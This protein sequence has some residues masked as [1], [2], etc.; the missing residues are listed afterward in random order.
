MTTTA[1]T[2]SDYITRTQNLL[3]AG[4]GGNVYPNSVLIP[5]INQARAQVAIE[6]ECIRAVPPVNGPVSSFT[7]LTAGSGY[8][9][10]PPTVIVSAPDSPSG[11]GISAAG[12][13]ARA[14][15]TL[16]GGAVV[17]ITINSGTGGAGY[18]Q[19]IVTL[20]S[21]SGTGATAIVVVSGLN[22]TSVSQEVYQFS[23][24]TPMVATSGSGIQSVYEVNGITVIWG[25]FRYRMKTCSFSK[26]K[27]VG[28]PYT[29]GYTYIPAVYSQFGQ[30][31]NGSIYA[32][33]IAN[34]A[35]QWEWDCFCLPNDLNVAT[36]VEAL[37][38]PWT[39]AVPFYAAYYAY[40]QNGRM[41]DADRMWK[42]AGKMMTRARTFSRRR[43]VSNWYGR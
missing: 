28:S 23:S 5:Y 41:A 3:G 20:A 16:S 1:P 39:D 25:T 17:A 21:G 19:P 42:E 31:V 7:I 22:V 10:S 13:Q 30:G 18:F 26:Y 34:A 8:G 36:D 35:Y 32:Y 15:A 24:V 12:Q 37:P 4:S 9:T 11:V 29:A 38:Y 2:I 43:M 40:Q 6:G 33:P 14:T 27:A